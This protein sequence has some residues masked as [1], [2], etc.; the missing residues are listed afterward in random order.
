MLHDEWRMANE[1]GCIL[2]VRNRNGL[3]QK[4]LDIGSPL[5]NRSVRAPG[6]QRL[7]FE[8]HSV[9]RVSSRG[10]S[11]FLTSCAPWSCRG[12]TCWRKIF[13]RDEK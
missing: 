8:G 3:G 6:L 9:G 11:V 4:V 5:K 12:N 10:A 7:N 1:P 13:E 2:F